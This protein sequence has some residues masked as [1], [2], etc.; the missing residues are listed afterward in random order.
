M[1]GKVGPTAIS[2]DVIPNWM[3][4]LLV[5]GQPVGYVCIPN[6]RLGEPE[7]SGAGAGSKE[8]ARAGGNSGGGAEEAVADKTTQQLRTLGD[9]RAVICKKLMLTDGGVDRV[10][11]WIAP[12]EEDRISGAFPSTRDE[13]D[14]K[15]NAESENRPEKPRGERATSDDMSLAHYGLRHLSVVDVR[16]R[17]AARGSA[18]GGSG[19]TGSEGQAEGRE[20][21]GE[22]MKGEQE[23]VV[24]IVVKTNQM[25]ARAEGGKVRGCLR[26]RVCFYVGMEAYR[27]AT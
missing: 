22:E 7:G 18:G 8:A 17:P 6:R 1:W 15:G 16:L 5:L 25:M 3:V 26:V 19:A 9:L 4:Q 14:G 27:V 21:K 23:D 11:L 12:P 10:A 24:R 20:K 2:A 13:G